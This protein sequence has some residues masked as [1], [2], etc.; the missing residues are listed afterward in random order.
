MSFVHGLQ[1]GKKFLCH[2][3][4]V[5]EGSVG[6]VCVVEGRKGGLIDDFFLEGK[7]RGFVGVEFVQ[8]L[9][10]GRGQGSLSRSIAIFRHFGFRWW[11]LLVTPTGITISKS[12]TPG[13]MVV[14][15]G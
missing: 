13:N 1:G 4:L 5:L 6:V 14:D 9:Y 2:L 11:C 7:V 8:L 15:V 12:A 3:D 10:G